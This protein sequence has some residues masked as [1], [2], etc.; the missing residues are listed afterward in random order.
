[1]AGIPYKEAYRL[2]LTQC[3]A[4]R[5]DEDWGAYSSLFFLSSVLRKCGD[6]CHR[7]VLNDWAAVLWASA[8]TTPSKS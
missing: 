6:A 7:D 8:G 5:P 2:L 3:K 1:M 4:L